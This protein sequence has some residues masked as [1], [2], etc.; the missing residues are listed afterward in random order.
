MP[1]STRQSNKRQLSSESKD[2]E[3]KQKRTRINQDVKPQLKTRSI[4]VK[5]PPRAITS[6]R[7][8]EGKRSRPDYA[9]VKMLLSLIHQSTRYSLGLYNYYPDDNNRS[10]MKDEDGFLINYDIDQVIE[11]YEDVEYYNK[12]YFSR[13]TLLLSRN[14]LD[15]LQIDDD[16]CE[17]IRLQINFGFIARLAWT[18]YNKLSSEGKTSYEK[19]L[20]EISYGHIN[21]WL[22]INWPS[23]STLLE[24]IVAIKTQAAIILMRKEDCEEQVKKLFFNGYT[25]NDQLEESGDYLIWTS[26]FED[27]LLL[28]QKKRYNVLKDMS[29]E[30]AI[31][32]FPLQEFQ[33]QI[34][35]FFVTV[36]LS[37]QYLLDVAQDTKTLVIS[38]Q[39]MSAISMEFDDNLDE[40]LD[41]INL[42]SPQAGRTIMQ[43]C[44]EKVDKAQQRWIVAVN[45][46]NED[47]IEVNSIV[48]TV[49]KQPKK[50]SFF[51]RNKTATRV[52]W[53]QNE[54]NSIL[55]KHQM[56]L[57][58]MQLLYMGLKMILL[59]Q[60]MTATMNK[61]RE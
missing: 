36:A 46:S 7:V 50:L 45:D 1:P 43:R 31:K 39:V 11:Y 51:T 9:K 21:T 3:S 20:T 47:E 18:D 22:P 30:K 4:A 38:P 25:R 33:D 24:N 35:L 60:T 40:M 29:L 8:A 58:L 12:R 5:T 52:E 56:I 15:Y 41:S 27:D 32:A 61:K 49:D 37:L 26:T 10:E 17:C 13:D 59:L 19:L 2:S 54:D 28:M 23:N 6:N 57:I 14:Y 16:E 55:D 42:P 34:R 48:E 44:I 53:S